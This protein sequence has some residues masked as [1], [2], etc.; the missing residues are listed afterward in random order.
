MSQR[1][2]KYVQGHLRWLPPGKAGL[3]SGIT[4]ALVFFLTVFKR[5]TVSK[6]L[7]LISVCSWR[8][9][10]H[11]PQGFIFH[12]CPEGLG[13]GKGIPGRRN[14]MNKDIT[15]P[16]EI[17][18]I[19]AW[20]IILTANSPIAL[21]L[22]K[23]LPKPCLYSYLSFKAQPKGCFLYENFPDHFSWKQPHFLSFLFLFFFFVFLFFFCCTQGIWKFSDLW[24]G[25]S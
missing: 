12:L 16:W 6:D 20:R 15:L 19:L 7:S 11:R 9:A 22:C 2:L 3:L 13:E 21:T 10:S 4:S 23:I 8:W 18:N 24:S 17:A 5:E 1:S 25:W 14:I